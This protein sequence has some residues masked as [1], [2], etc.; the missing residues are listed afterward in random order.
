MTRA[1][2]VSAAS[3]TQSHV[4]LHQR[5]GISWC[6]HLVV[7]ILMQESWWRWCRSGQSAIPWQDHGRPW[8]TTPLCAVPHILTRYEAHVLESAGLQAF[9]FGIFSQ[10]VHR[11]EGRVGGR[12]VLFEVVFVLHCLDDVHMSLF[13]RHRLAVVNR[14]EFIVQ[15]FESCPQSFTGILW[16]CWRHWRRH[17]GRIGIED[18]FAPLQTQS[19]LL[20]CQHHVTQR[21]QLPTVREE[22]NKNQTWNTLWTLMV[23]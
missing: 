17:G 2:I 11:G 22:E 1:W 23:D 13:L 8:Y 5:W 16:L 18:S 7:M 21:L 15:R 9:W 4:S 3:A 19:L 20:L 10:R 12:R 6:Y 14:V